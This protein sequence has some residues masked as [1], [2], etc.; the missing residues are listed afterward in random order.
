MPPP[1]HAEVAAQHGAIVEG[2]EE[3]L[4]ERLDP[5]EPLSV[6][7]GCDTECLGTRMRGLRGDDLTLEHPEAGRGSPHAV[8][9]WHPLSVRKTRPRSGPRTARRTTVGRPV[10][11]ALRSRQRN[12]GASRRV[13]DLPE[14]HAATIESM[15]TALEGWRSTQGQRADGAVESL[16]VARVDRPIVAT[17]EAGAAVLGR[18][19]WATVRDATRG[20]RLSARGAGSDGGSSLPARPAPPL[21]RRARAHG[22]E[23]PRRVPLPD[24]WR[25]ARTGAERRSHPGAGA[26][27]RRLSSARE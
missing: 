18:G 25:P 21:V 5:I 3:V 26:T 27:R 8:A 23:Q 22:R 20:D 9:L 16:Q 2:E 6:Y 10:A 24:H 17:S 19:Y 11:K 15:V 13:A 1:A 14:E 4:P 7:P 12:G